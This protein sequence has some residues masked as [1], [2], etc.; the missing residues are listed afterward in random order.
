MRFLYF[1]LQ[2]SDVKRFDGTVTAAW[3]RGT[4]A[5]QL[6]RSDQY[7]LFI[8]ETDAESLSD[9]RVTAGF[10]RLNVGGSLLRTQSSSRPCLEQVIVPRVVV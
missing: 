6:R 4:G 5:D 9:Y 1:R 10:R 3:S 2:S 7:C 8:S